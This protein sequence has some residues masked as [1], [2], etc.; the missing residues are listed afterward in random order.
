[1]AV[2]D[3]Y[4]ESGDVF[5]MIRRVLDIL[6]LALTTRM[7]KMVKHNRSKRLMMAPAKRTIQIAMEDHI[8]DYIQVE[9]AENKTKEDGDVEADQP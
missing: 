6:R 4:M 9:E 1:M 8:N 7:K 3:N 2:H 5:V